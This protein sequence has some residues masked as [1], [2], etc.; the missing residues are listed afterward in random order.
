MFDMED[1]NVLSVLNLKDFINLKML[2]IGHNHYQSFGPFNEGDEPKKLESLNLQSNRF[3]NSLF[4]SIKGLPSL[5]FLDLSM[6]DFHGPLPIQDINSLSSLEVLDLSENSIEGFETPISIS[7]VSGRIT[8]N[9]HLQL[10]L[11]SILCNMTKLLQSLASFQAVKSLELRGNNITTIDEIYGE[12]NE[13]SR[14]I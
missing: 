11:N 5:K 3:N 10:R 13:G 8:N 12:E 14:L 7:G 6:N 9:S 1:I 2:V 4:K